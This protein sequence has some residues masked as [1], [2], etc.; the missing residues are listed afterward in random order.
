MEHLT[1]T[2]KEVQLLMYL[3]MTRL[4]VFSF[5][6]LSIFQA[7]SQLLDVVILVLEYFCHSFRRR[8]ANKN[9]LISRREIQIYF[10][11]VTKTLLNSNCC[12]T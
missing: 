1:T 5:F 6:Q 2:Q 9:N 10:R 8:V 12:E 7:A 3:A 4:V 11:N